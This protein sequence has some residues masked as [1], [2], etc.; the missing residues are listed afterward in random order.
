MCYKKESCKH[1]ERILKGET[2]VCSNCEYYI[3]IKRTTRYSQIALIVSIILFIMTTY[4]V[5]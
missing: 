1:Y 2:N 5:Y 4:L 3:K